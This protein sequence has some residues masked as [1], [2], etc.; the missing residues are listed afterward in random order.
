MARGARN[1]SATPTGI[2]A[3]TS[4][5]LVYRE[6]PGD[7]GPDGV[8]ESPRLETVGDHSEPFVTRRGAVDEYHQA[9]DVLR[10]HQGRS[11]IEIGKTILPAASAR[12]IGGEQLQQGALM[13][14]VNSMTNEQ[15][16]KLFEYAGSV[17][18]QDQ[19]GALLLIFSAWDARSSK[20]RTPGANGA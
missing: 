20:E 14:L 12:L 15:P 1:H 2:E 3:S 11:A 19:V 8:D 9:I 18:N 16:D 4:E 7:L 6:I 5:P 13:S 10:A 17:L